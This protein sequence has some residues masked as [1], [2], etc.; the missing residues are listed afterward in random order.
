MTRHWRDFDPFFTSKAETY[1]SSS[2][3]I[4]RMST[5]IFRVSCLLP[6]VQSRFGKG[7]QRDGRA[8]ESWERFR[9]PRITFGDRFHVNPAFSR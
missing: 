2:G 6:N 9:D 5:T 7:D 1:K 3:A 4:I 8:I